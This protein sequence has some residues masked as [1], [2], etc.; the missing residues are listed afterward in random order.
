MSSNDVLL[1]ILESY[2]LPVGQI[3]FDD[4]G[5]SWLLSYSIDRDFRGRDYGYRIVD[6]GVAAALKVRSCPIRAIVKK[7][8]NASI[9]IFE[10]L[11]FVGQESDIS[12]SLE[13]VLNQ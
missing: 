4:Q 10:S 1:F 7:H 2:G 13:F 11:N 6:I 3:R 8:N 5:D 9:R 12:D